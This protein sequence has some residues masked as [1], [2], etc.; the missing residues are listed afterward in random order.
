MQSRNLRTLY[1]FC[2]CRW[3]EKCNHDVLNFFSLRWLREG[4]CIPFHYVILHVH[5]ARSSELYHSTSPSTAITTGSCNPLL[6]KRLPVTVCLGLSGSDEPVC[7]PKA[8][9]KF[10]PVVTI[11]SHSVTLPDDQFHKHNTTMCL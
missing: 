3:I 5:K 8:R 9:H 2:K 4:L 1:R 7:D 11:H 6:F 10:L